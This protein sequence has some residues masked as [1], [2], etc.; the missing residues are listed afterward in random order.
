VLYTM[1]QIEACLERAISIDVEKPF[2]QHGCTLTVY[3]AGHV[4]GAVMAH[5]QIGPASVLYTGDYNMVADRLLGAAKVPRLRPDLLITESTYATTLRD[6]R[7][8]RERKLLD[9]IH[10][11][12]RQGGKVLVPVYAVGSAQEL[13]LLVHSYWKRMRINVRLSCQ[14]ADSHA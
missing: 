13:S 8:A 3:Y 10:S 5:C 6:P 7:R 1:Q 4:M 2:H 9:L 12:V 14:V 11:T